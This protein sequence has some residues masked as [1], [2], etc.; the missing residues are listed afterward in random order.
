MSTLKAKTKV[1]AFARIREGEEI[2]TPYMH[3]KKT[4][5]EKI[6]YIPK[7]MPSVAFVRYSL[8]TWGIKEKVVQQA[9]INPMVSMVS[10]LISEELRISTSY[11]F[12]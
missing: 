10:I 1:S 3:H 2:I 9:A 5:V 8:M 4:P 6:R 12:F 11:V 7:E